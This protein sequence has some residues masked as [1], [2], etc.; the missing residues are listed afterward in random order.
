MGEKIK[1]LGT[2]FDFLDIELNKATFNGGPRYIHIQNQKIRF[3]VSESVF[4]QLAS[5]ILK[6]ETVFENNKQ[7]EELDVCE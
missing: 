4:M 7:M 3:C 1:V 6:A 5:S 2:V